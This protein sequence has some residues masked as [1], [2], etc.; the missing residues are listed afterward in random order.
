MFELSFIGGLPGGPELMI[1]LLLAVL[2][3]GSSKLPKLA[4][5]SGEAIG[6]FQKGREQIETEIRESRA[7]TTAE[8]SERPAAEAATGASD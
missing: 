7:A 5:A 6:E 8:E 3:F 1:I 4:R 2:L